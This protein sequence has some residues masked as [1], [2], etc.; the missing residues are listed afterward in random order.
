MKR[1]I[2]IGAVILLV[3]LVGGGFWLYQRVFGDTAA[4]SGPISAIP[5]A[6]ESGASSSGSLRFQIV[7]EQS[8]VRFTISEVLRGQPN[9]VVGKSNQVAGEIAVDSNDLSTAKVG[10]IRIDVRTLQT[11]NAM[12]N[13]AIRNFILNTNTYEYVTFTPTQIRGL[14]GKAELGKTLTFQIAGDLTIRDV[15]KPVVFDV[16]AHADTPTQLSGTASTAISR[17]DYSL[18]IP[19]VPFVANVGEQVKLDIDFVAQTSST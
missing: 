5:L 7:P 1:T 19:S 14:S 10:A 11:D 15:T 12:R 17:A 9:T 18:T 8:E 13:R 3:V 2:M 4:S 6:Q 16:T